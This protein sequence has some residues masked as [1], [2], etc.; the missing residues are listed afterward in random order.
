M[1]DVIYYVALSFVMSDDSPAARDG[2][3]C[4]SASAAILRA[5]RLARTE[6]NISAVA[7]SRT[8]DPALGDFSDAVVLRAFAGDP[9]VLCTL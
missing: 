4:P 1:A 9:N 6:G 8:G 5:E 7:C 2:V 3:E